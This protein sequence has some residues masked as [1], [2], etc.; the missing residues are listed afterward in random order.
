MPLKDNYPAKVGIIGQVYQLYTRSHIP[1]FS[2][3]LAYYALF[4]LMPLLILLAGIFGFVLSGNEDLRNAVLVRLIELV[5]VLFPTQPDLAQTVVSFLTR[6][7]FP[8]TFASLLILLW[9][10]SNFFA[11]LAYA[12]GIIFGR[13]SPLSEHPV[14]LLEA[15]TPDSHPLRRLLHQGLNVLRVMRGRIAG[16]LAPLLLGLA[17]ILL[18]LMG[19]AMGFLLRYL[20][21]DLSFLRG[22]VEVVV[23]ILGALLLFFLTYMLLPIPTPRVLA[24]FAAAT[25][26][27][28]AW[29]GVR[30]GLPL[31]LPR[32]QYELIYGP[33]AGFLLALAGFY[34]TMWILLV[35]ALLAKILTDRSSDA[36]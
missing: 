24:A 28:L 15:A 29:E 36:I 23:P 17:L 3:A 30:L 1:F 25:L 13:L 4:S 14:A 21:A 16:L 9:A 19:L 33:I 6:G 5:V 22:G 10:S 7:A 35:G 34:L 26:A 32:T 27:A 31:L 20:P 11:A 2:A 8:L 12:L 18:A